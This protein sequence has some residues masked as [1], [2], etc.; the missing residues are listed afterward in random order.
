MEKNSV[1]VTKACEV[2]A[3][4]DRKQDVTSRGAQ[5]WTEAW[6]LM[7]ETPNLWVVPFDVKDPVHTP[8]Q[9]NVT[10]RRCARR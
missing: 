8:R 7:D 1:D 5:V 4:W 2:L 6:P 10:T 9:I 3:A